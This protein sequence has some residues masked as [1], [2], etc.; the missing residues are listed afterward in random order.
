MI[1]PIKRTESIGG[2]RT[3]LTFAGGGGGGSG[4]AVE[5]RHAG[6]AARP[7][8]VVQTLQT[9]AA[10]AIA[11]SLHA[12]VDVSVTPAGA[13]GLLVDVATR[14]RAVETLPTDVT[15]RT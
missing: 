3:V 6:L 5:T 14:R 13:A 12:D 9:F 10:A 15:A 7:R 11:A 1:I 8:R 4:S 2:V